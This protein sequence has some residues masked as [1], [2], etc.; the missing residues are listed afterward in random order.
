MPSPM[1][2][3]G[4]SPTPA[5]DE[6]RTLEYRHTRANQEKPTSGLRPTD[7]VELS[8]SYREELTS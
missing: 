7:R 4:E 8:P 1:R 3:V 6:T 5:P 2:Q